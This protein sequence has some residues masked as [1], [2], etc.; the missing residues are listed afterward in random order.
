MLIPRFTVR[1][2]FLLM[3]VCSVFFLI[4]A[5]AVRGQLWAIALSVAITSAVVAF[6]CYGVFFGLAYVLAS[7]FG[8]V[9]SRPGGGTPFATA[10]PPPQIIPPEEP[11]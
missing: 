11:E 6:L 9:R 8:L 10:A 1:W 5:S 2:L 4:V 3:T 7:L